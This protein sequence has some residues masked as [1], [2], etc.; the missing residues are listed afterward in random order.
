MNIVIITGISG[1]KKSE[2]LEN[3]LKKTGIKD[4]SQVIKFEDELTRQKRRAPGIIPPASVGAFLDQDSSSNKVTAIEQTFS[5]ITNSIRINK[6]TQYVFLDIHLEYYK[7]T[8]YFP[9]LNPAHFRG[10][11][12]N[13]DPDA[14]VKI[15]NLIDDVFNIWQVL[16]EREEKYP[17]TRLTLREILAW[18]SLETLQSESLAAS[19]AAGA[20]QKSAV[21]YMVS[22]K[23]PFSTF[24][25]LIIPEVPASIY[26][27]YPISKTRNV[28]KRVEQV[29]DFRNKVHELGKK[30]NVAVFDPVTI[31]ELILKQTSKERKS[32]LA[33]SLR[34]PLES[35][36]LLIDDDVSDIRLPPSEI[37]DSISYVEHQVKSRDLKLVEQ[38]ALLVVFRPFYGGMSTGALAEIRHAKNLGMDV[39]IYSP[40]DDRIDSS[41]NPFDTS[42]API[43]SADEFY[44]TIETKLET[45]SPNNKR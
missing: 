35:D 28:K 34:W 31:D 25:N 32:V 45:L 7:K 17:N 37:D 27:S 40:S 16:K 24:R 21:P 8:E 15:I 26:L 38:A 4:V 11:I 39:C 33:Q 6:N 41:D 14:N 9:P 44:K 29:N 42:F 12:D 20:G 36:D 43:Q 18:R 1:I 2:F 5:W 22:I 3:F 30:Y 23:H 13:I 10:W 19:I